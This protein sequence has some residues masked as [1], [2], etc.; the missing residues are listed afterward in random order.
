MDREGLALRIRKTVDAKNAVMKITQTMEPIVLPRQWQEQV[1]E[2][3]H[4]EMGHP[5]PDRLL[6]TVSRY[7]VWRKMR[8]RIH[9]YCRT[10]MHCQKRKSV[11]HIIQDPALSVYPKMTRPFDRCHMDLF[12]ELP[13]TD[14]GFK[15]VLVFKCALTKWVEYFALRSKSKEDVAECFIDEIL[16]RHGAPKVLIS[17]GGKEFVNDVMKAVCVMLKIRK[18]TTAPYNPRADGLAENQVKTCKDMLTSYCNVF[19]TDWDKYLSVVAHYYRTTYNDA[20]NMTPFRALYGR[21]CTQVNTMWIGEVLEENAEL[22]E[23]VENLAVVMIA[24]W[25]ALGLSVY[26]NGLRMKKQQAKGRQLRMHQYAVGDWVMAKSVPK[27]SF[28]SEVVIDKKKQ[29]TKIR[30]ALQDR[31]R[32]PY[33]VVRIISE[34][35]IVCVINGK[36]QHMA[37]KNL[38]P[39]YPAVIQRIAVLMT[40]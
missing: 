36:E 31:Y 32:G 15:Y 13:E 27:G 9:V 29:K 37:Y 18:V 21:E 4:L 5:G 3:Y 16:M 22:P 10:C 40:S 25:E 39:F 1:I 30:A 38:K 14:S 26:E 17:D 2:Q 12:G 28:V 23:Y 35:T 20:I 34:K 33:K 6:Q 8:R 7:Y 11:S 24:V 19:Q